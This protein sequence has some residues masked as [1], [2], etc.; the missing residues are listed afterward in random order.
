MNYY[1]FATLTAANA[2]VAALAASLV[3]QLPSSPSIGFV[4]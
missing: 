3:P 2:L 1:M 4:Y